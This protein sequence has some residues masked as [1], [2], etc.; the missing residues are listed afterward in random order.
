MPLKCS[1]DTFSR[2][3]SVP[4]T[5]LAVTSQE[6]RHRPTGSHVRSRVRLEPSCSWT[7]TT[8]IPPWVVPT[9]KSGEVLPQVCSW[10]CQR[11][12]EAYHQA[13]RSATMNGSGH[14]TVSSVAT[15]PLRTLPPNNSKRVGLRTG[16]GDQVMR[17]VSEDEAVRPGQANRDASLSPTG[18]AIERRLQADCRSLSS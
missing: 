10:P 13:F 1:V 5:R 18:R 3:P 7:G 8:L 4:P 9:W 15:H 12:S 17:P 16:S 11:Y 2:R 14:Q 6:R